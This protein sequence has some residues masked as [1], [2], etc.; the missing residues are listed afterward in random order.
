VYADGKLSWYINGLPRP[1]R[2]IPS[3]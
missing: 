2:K 3:K 1:S